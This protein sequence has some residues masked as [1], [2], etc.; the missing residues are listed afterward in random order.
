MDFCDAPWIVEDSAMSSSAVDEGAWLA[1]CSLPSVHMSFVDPAPAIDASEC[2][3]Q[4][5]GLL[6]GKVGDACILLCETQAKSGSARLSFFRD[7]A[8]AWRVD[9]QGRE[10]ESLTVID[11]QISIQIKSNEQS[12]IL[13]RWKQ[14]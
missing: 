3:E 6:T 8:E 2:Q 1:Q 4:K 11:G 5:A 10:F 12:R 14:S 13:M 7:V 9:S